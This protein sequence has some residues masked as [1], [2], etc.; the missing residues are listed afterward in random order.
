[1]NTVRLEVRSFDDVLGDVAK[2]W[3]TGEATKPRI[4]FDSVE[5][6]WKALSPKKMDILKAMTGAGQLGIREVS[7]KVERDVSAVHRDLQALIVA[8]IVDRTDEGKVVFPYDEIH[9]DFTLRGVA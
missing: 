8:G 5:D 2:A 1:M 7:R 4:S 9:V 6:L 3:K